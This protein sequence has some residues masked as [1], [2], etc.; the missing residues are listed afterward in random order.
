M[1]HGGNVWQGDSPDQWLDYSANIRPEGAP[2]WVKNALAGAMDKLSYYPD[3]Q[4][5]KAKSALAEYLG[6]DREYVLPAA[7]GISAIDMSTHLESTGMLQF[8]PL[9]CGILDAQREPWQGDRQ[10]PAAERKTYHR[11]SC[12]AGKGAVV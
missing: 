7:G 4:M 6:I 8:T 12:R 1:I 5:K 10:H 11:R 3:P 9:F 2:Q